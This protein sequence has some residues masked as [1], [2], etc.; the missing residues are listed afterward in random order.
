MDVQAPV[1]P[2]PTPFVDALVGVTGEVDKKDLFP[3]LLEDDGEEEDAILSPNS[4]HHLFQGTGRDLHDGRSLPSCLA[5]VIQFIPAVPACVAEMK[6][7]WNKLFSN[8]VSIKGFAWLNIQ[9]LEELSLPVA[10]SLRHFRKGKSGIKCTFQRNTSIHFHSCI[11]LFLKG[12]S[13]LFRIHLRLL[14]MVVLTVTVIPL[15][16]LRIREFQRWTAIGCWLS[17]RVITSEEC[18]RALH[19]WRIPTFLGGNVWWQNIAR[20]VVSI[21]KG[22]THKLPG[23]TNSVPSFK[24]LCSFPSGI[25]CIGQIR[26][27]NGGGLHKL[28]R[29]CVLLTVSQSNSQNNCVEQQV[30]AITC[31]TSTR[32]NAQ[33]VDLFCAEGIP[34]MEN[35]HFIHRWWFNL[36]ASYKIHSVLYSFP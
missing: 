5:P 11:S 1:L 8:H 18:G 23:T 10:Q 33:G 34:F 25:S 13:V 7:H 30:S 26:Q 17:R 31:N 32:N 4:L 29:V 36:F 20:R 22:K 14:G 2:P 12:R 9:D 3:H 19:H 27:H 6:R 21:S 24:P 28:T 16:L 35:G 15:G